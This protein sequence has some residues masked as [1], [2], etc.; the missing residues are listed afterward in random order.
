MNYN[1]QWSFHL[2]NVPPVMICAFDRQ[3]TRA[4]WLFIDFHFEGSKFA[5]LHSWI[6]GDLTVVLHLYKS[7]RS[8]LEEKHHSDGGT[9]RK[10][11]VTHNSSRFFFEPNQPPK[12]LFCLLPGVRRLYN[13]MRSV[14]SQS[15]RGSLQSI[16]TCSYHKKSAHQYYISSL[17]RQVSRSSTRIY[18]LLSWCVD[19]WSREDTKVQFQFFDVFCMLTFTKCGRYKSYDVSIH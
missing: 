10:E 13:H 5:D 19:W 7:A 12:A 3:F 18:L 1:K 11:P 16:D 6:S 8:P 2:R 4:S 9:L 14:S 17:S 15:R